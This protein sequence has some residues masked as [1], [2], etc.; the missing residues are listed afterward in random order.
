MQTLAGEY[1]PGQSRREKLLRKAAFYAADSI[2]MSNRLGNTYAEFTS[3]D[4]PIQCAMCIFDCSQVLAEWITTVQER[5]GPYMGVLGRDEIDATQ[6]PG[7]LLLEDEDCK[8]IDKIKEI[9]STVE[10]KMQ[11]SLQNST[12]VSA[13]SALQ[14]L[15]SVV[16]G[17]YGSKIL[18]AASSLLDRSGVWPVTKLMARSFE[19][20][21]L[22]LK[23]RAEI[24]SVMGTS[25]RLRS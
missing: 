24:S 21:A 9:L 5:V 1:R 11:Q 19:S 2:S 23:E 13:L 7:I 15:P 17:G 18:I 25:Q 14:R 6:V 8:L 3:R 4:L 20:Q 22:R 16:E 10:A 12:T